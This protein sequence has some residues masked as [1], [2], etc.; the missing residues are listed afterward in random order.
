MKV[1]VE[2]LNSGEWIAR[3]WGVVVGS[4]GFYPY[5]WTVV[6]APT[7]ARAKARFI[8]LHQEAATKA[9]LRGRSV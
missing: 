1:S 6:Y 3:P 7:A 9:A 5:P 2:Q 4:N 8:E